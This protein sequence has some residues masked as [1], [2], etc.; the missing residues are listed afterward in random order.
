M[1]TKF[2]PHRVVNGP[3]AGALGPAPSWGPW[4]RAG[5]AL[6]VS[7]GAGLLAWAGRRAA[8]AGGRRALKGMDA[9]LLRDIGVSREQALREAA[10]PFWRD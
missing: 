5:F 6:L 10:K 3:A 8:M 4:L 9:R 7:D 2:L 1:V